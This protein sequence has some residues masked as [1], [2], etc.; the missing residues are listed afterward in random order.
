EAD[1][2]ADEL[3]RNNPV[4]GGGSGVLAATAVVREIGGFDEKLS[5]LADWDFYLRL[6]QRARLAGVPRPLVG[7]VIHAGGMAHDV[8]RS[9]RE[10]RYVDA[11]HAGLRAA[12]GVEL[13]RGAFLYYVATMAYRAGRRWTGMRLHAELALRHGRL[14]SLRSIAMGLVPVRYYLHRVRRGVRSVSPQWLCQAHEWLGA[15]AG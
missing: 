1:T 7:Y 4:P 8:V 5:N 13:D 9:L 10:F 15:C 3:L 12:R 2:A 11:K 14:R 6:G